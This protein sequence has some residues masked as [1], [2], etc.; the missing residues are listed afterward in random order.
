MLLALTNADRASDLHLELNVK[1]VL[2]HGVRFQIAGLSKTRRSDP[3]QEVMYVVFKECEAI[4]PVA[5]LETYER[6]TADLLT[7]DQDTNP[8]FIGCVKLIS[9][10]HL[11]QF[12][13]GSGT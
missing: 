12:L 6:R 3:P 9:P 7:P 8:P 4:C 13:D 2:S 5:T 11:V 10:S 1:Q